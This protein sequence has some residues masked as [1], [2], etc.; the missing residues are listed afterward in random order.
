MLNFDLLM[1]LVTRW[2]CILIQWQQYTLGD[3]LD[4]Q[5]MGVTV[6]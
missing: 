6:C 3:A 4:N 5:Q 1:V 2:S